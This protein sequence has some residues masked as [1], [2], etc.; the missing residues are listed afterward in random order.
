MINESVKT[1]VEDLKVNFNAQIK[2]LNDKI[3]E[4]TEQ[5]DLMSAELK[6][7]S[8]ENST[9]K[10]QLLE[11]QQLTRELEER[12]EGRTNLS[13]RKTLIFQNVPEVEGENW[14]QTTNILANVIVKASCNTLTLEKANI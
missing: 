12:L 8:Q 9:L 3:S 14:G 13:L 10:E 4:V 5:V 11:Q 7:V 1:A 6:E 2:T